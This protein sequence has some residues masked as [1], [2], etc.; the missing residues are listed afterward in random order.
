VTSDSSPGNGLDADLTFALRL[1]DTAD[2]ITMRGFR[3]ADL[4]VRTKPDLT[5]VTEIDQ[6]VERQLREIVEAEHPDDSILG[7]EYG[8]ERSDVS[9]DSHTAATRR[10]IIDPI[11]GTKN[12]VRGVPVWATLIALASEDDIM[13]GVVSAPALGRRWWAATGH[14][15]FSQG[16]ED[17][18]PRRLTVS[19]VRD[20]IDASVSFSDPT[21]WPAGS[22]DRL[23]EATWR[24]RA[25]G[26]FW[27]HLLV[28]EGAVDIAGEPELNLW[29]IAALVPIVTEA[30]GRITSYTGGVPLDSALTTNG[31]L[32]DAALGMLSAT[33]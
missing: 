24:M 18:Q 26:D 32:H 1:A 5:P 10:W 33:D 6:A 7:E 21:G 3:S 14:G 23:H 19:G 11:D 20:L 4:V 25:Y 13:L 2:T 12:F 16:P 8:E 27:S 15:A 31:H 9:A 30:G 17:A 29:D 28:A 22:L